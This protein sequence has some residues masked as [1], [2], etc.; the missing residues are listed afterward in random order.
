MMLVVC[1]IGVALIKLTQIRGVGCVYSHSD[2][3][4]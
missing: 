1:D 4:G 2:L 3:R